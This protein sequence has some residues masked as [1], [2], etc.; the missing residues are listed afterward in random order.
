MLS[1]VLRRLLLI[2][3]TL[4]GMTALVFFVVALSPGG[5]G[6]A[7][8]GQAVGMRPSEREA[9]RRYYNGRYGLDKPYLVQ[10]V[11]WLNNISPVGFRTWKA[12]DPPVAEATR[13]ELELRD[14]R[15]R[16]M[17]AAGA[18]QLDIERALTR[19]D[20][21]PSPGDL[22]LTRP[23]VKAPH[24]G[25]SYARGRRVGGMIL[26]AL[27]VTLLLNAISLPLTYGVA[28][29]VG[30]YAARHRGQ[31]FDKASGTAFLALWSVPPILAGVLLIGYLANQ[32]YLKWFPSAEMSDMLAGSM[33]FLPTRAPDGSWQRGWLL[34]RAWHLALPV[35]CLSY[36]PFAFLSK[37]SRGAVL[38]N[39]RADYVRTARAKGVGEHDVL[40]RHVLSN[41]LIPLI[42][43]AAH[44]LPALIAGSV[45]VETIFSVPG[46]G[47]LLVDSIKLKDREVFLSITM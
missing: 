5:S 20:L 13:R 16:E 30:I 45:V 14:A 19:I 34:D 40:F 26:E 10:Y 35:L 12:D 4:V 6:A 24:F 28:T 42:T 43:Q 17:R 15:Q 1:Y 2:V 44:L 33:S 11:R 21:S 32:Q 29:L 7:L 9:L 41:S 36:G 18:T 27:P 25:E 31:L 37:L 46:M 8:L 23:A 22:R 38:E 39:M 3:P 47:K